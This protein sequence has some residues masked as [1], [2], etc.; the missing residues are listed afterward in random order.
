MNDIERHIQYSSG[1][2]VAALVF[3]DHKTMLRGTVAYI[4]LGSAYESVLD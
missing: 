4:S 1:H 3:G 2:T